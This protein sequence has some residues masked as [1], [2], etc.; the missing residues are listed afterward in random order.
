MKDTFD[1]IVDGIYGLI[2]MGYIAAAIILFIKGGSECIISSWGIYAFIL[3]LISI[4]LLSIIFILFHK[5]HKIKGTYRLKQQE[6]ENKAQNQQKKY[7]EKQQNLESEYRRKH[8]ELDKNK[9]T[10][11]E[12]MKDSDPLFLVSSFYSNLCTM[13]FEWS[14]SYLLNKSHPAKT[15]AEEVKKYRD[16]ANEYGQKC[17]EM[18][19][20]YE[21]LLNLFPELS[22]YV[23]DYESIKELANL[24]DIN[25]VKDQYDRRRDWLSKEEYAKLSDDEK[26]QRALDNYIKGR[27]SKWQI[28]RDYELYCGY[29]IRK[30][31][32]TVFQNGVSKKL[33]DL[34]RDIIAYNESYIYIIQC[35]NWSSNKLIH[36]KHINQLFGTCTEY[37][38]TESTLKKVVPVF[39]TTIDLSDRAKKF[40]QILG[41]KVLKWSMDEFPRIKCNINSDEEKIYHLPFDQ[42]YDRTLIINPGECYA[43]TIK[44]AV[45][46]GFRRAK[47]HIPPS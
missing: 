21:L 10:F 3:L 47:K 23:E 5:M 38:V 41:V 33:D 16:I 22:Q 44:E 17:K 29:K 15:A 12:I 40:A 13:C 6:L 46:K 14:S 37:R 27:K 43:F 8:N 31:G 2:V 42:Q 1:E 20:K 19:Y 45:D 28:G 11:I 18:Q 32:L 34:G 25:D 4:A 26:S 9:N 36:E 7:E 39:I 30:C 24:K 35:K